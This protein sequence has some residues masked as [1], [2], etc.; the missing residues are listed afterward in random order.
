MEGVAQPGVDDERSV[1]DAALERG[2]IDNQRLVLCLDSPLAQRF[3]A[4]QVVAGADPLDVLRERVSLKLHLAR[5]L[6]T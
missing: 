5:P 1:C 2:V 6:P 4:L 3:V